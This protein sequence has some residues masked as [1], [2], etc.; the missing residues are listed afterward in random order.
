M[1]DSKNPINI[2][3][4]QLSTYNTNLGKVASLSDEALK[5][6]ELSSNMPNLTPEEITSNKE[7]V[8]N[9]LAS[10]QELMSK[11]NKAD[12]DASMIASLAKKIEVREVQ[13]SGSY[14]PSLI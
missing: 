5:I 14:R 7:L 9:T 12:N 1:T 13:R 6:R 8:E 10:V 3:K 11:S 2:Y 4:Y